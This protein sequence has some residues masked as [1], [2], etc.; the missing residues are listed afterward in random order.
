[1]VLNARYRLCDPGKL[2][3][4]MQASDIY[5][6][7]KWAVAN[8]DMLGIDPTKIIMHGLSGGGHVVMAQNSYLVQK[9]E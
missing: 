8:A 7:I 4:P 2:T 3:A 9:G 1:V 5:G 6:Q